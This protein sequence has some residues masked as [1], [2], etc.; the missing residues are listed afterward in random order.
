MA[1]ENVNNLEKGMGLYGD[2][3]YQ[4]ALSHTK[5]VSSAEDIYQ[6]VFL[7]LFKYQ[8]E[9][10]DEQHMKAW[11]IRVTLN[12]SKDLWRSAWFRYTSPLEED[13]PLIEEEKEENVYE[14]VL[15]L[16]SKYRVVV[17]LFYYEEMSISE[18]SKVLK[19]REGTISSR[20]NRAR[21]LLKDKL[22]GEYN[23]GRF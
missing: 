17:H 23:Y 11:L 4:L 1:K 12:S 3:V 8:K 22:K 15:K 18:I 13:I 5:N 7:K 21:K 14:H 9:F 10:C 19:V 2:M 16:S 6:E 20:L